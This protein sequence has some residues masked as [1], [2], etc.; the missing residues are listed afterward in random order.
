MLRE[1]RFQLSDFFAQSLALCKGA[2]QSGSKIALILYDRTLGNS[3][4]ECSG[5]ITES[6]SSSAT[7]QSIISAPTKKIDQLL[8][9]QL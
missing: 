1:G 4:Q 5:L 2:F 7:W 3:G 9:L 6:P 8:I